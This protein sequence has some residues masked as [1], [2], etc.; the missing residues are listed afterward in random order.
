MCH[1]GLRS[2]ICTLV[3]LVLTCGLSA[4]QP[5]PAP[6]ERTEGRAPCADFSVLR[7]PLVGELHLHTGLSIDAV[8]FDD[9]NEPRDAYRFARGLPIGIAPYDAMGQPLRTVQLGR[10]LDFA[11]VTDHAEGFGVETICLTPGLPGYDAPEC[12]Q[13]RNDIGSFIPGQVPPSFLSLV[14]PGVLAPNAPPPSF[15][16]SDGAICRAQDSVIW[17]TVQAAA[18][19]FYDRTDACSFTTLV[20]YEWSGT[21]LNAN[22]HRNVIFRNE[23]VPALPTSYIQEPTVQGLWARL[24]AQCLDGLDRCDVLAIPHN[25]NVSNGLMFEPVNA[26]GSPLNAADAATRAGFEPL[27]EMFQ[28]KG[29]SECRPGVGTVDELC[30]FEKLT[31][32]T[33]FGGSA[34]SLYPP[35]GFVR[36]ALKEGL[37][38]EQAL[39]ANPFK[40][41]FIGATDTHNAT[42]GAA[43]E[44]RYPGHLGTLDATAA[45]RLTNSSGSNI[46]NNPGGLA[47]VWAEENSRDAIF[48]AMRRRETYAT[49]GP[50]PLVRMFAGELPADLC[51][52][53]DFVRA[54]YTGGVPMGGEIGV[55]AG[56]HSPR[57]AVLAFKDPGTEASPGTALQR[58]QIVKGWVDAAG[59]AQEKVFDV[60]GDAA[61]GATV[62]LATCT[63]QGLGFDSLCTVWEDPEF[64]AGRRAFYYARI[65]ENPTCRWSTRLCIAEAVDCSSPTIPPELA[66]CCSDS[67]P[68]TVQER[69]WTSPI[70]Y[71]P[72][73]IGRLTA[74]LR[75][76]AAVDSADHLTL[77]A[78][79]GAA[80]NPDRDDVAI[81]VR[82]DDEILRVVVP[83]A[84]M[85]RHSTRPRWTL[86][87]AGGVA[88]LTVVVTRAGETRL[89]LRTAPADL[90]SAALAD[91]FV[92]VE[93]SSGTYRGHHTRLWRLD[94]GRLTTP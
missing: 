76:R 51:E 55:V 25:S 79:L 43:D 13:L 35:L 40:L 59:L 85:R 81:A 45:F 92:D 94:R 61:N 56:T 67:I 68:K 37:V 66:L 50:R 33:L 18:E 17:Q 38:Q 73:G 46:E 64:D 87:D 70:W 3:L 32:T 83:A 36:N 20:A 29:D 14:I 84:T 30:G 86:R 21:P 19:E 11:A 15:C 72:E 8:V 74:T 77:R 69:V 65:L 24:Q 41:G 57:F 27:V 7:R 82:D 58:A 44:D 39:G 2:L 42:A 53:P 26:D 4:A 5:A 49:S 6:W 60:A 91:H 31:R 78:H 71:R 63:P 75:R 88:R 48:S 52:D 12:A 62:D 89:V 9:R 22:L 34:P 1:A 28:H 10:P 54:G 93:I 80:L 16:G 23:Q 47:I 90:A